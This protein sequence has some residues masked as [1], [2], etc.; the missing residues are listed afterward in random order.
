VPPESKIS[1]SWS[2][3]PQK[4]LSDNNLIG[5]KAEID[6]DRARRAFHK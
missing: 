5:S 1:D 6:C 2:R 4:A 3:L